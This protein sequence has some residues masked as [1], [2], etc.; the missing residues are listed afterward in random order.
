VKR[1]LDQRERREIERAR[2]LIHGVPVGGPLVDEHLATGLAGDPPDHLREV[3]GRP[4]LVAPTGAGVD[5]EE[6]PAIVPS[7]PGQGEAGLSAPGFRRR[8][9]YGRR[10]RLHSPRGERFKQVLPDCGR[11]P[12]LWHRWLDQRLG[13]DRSQAFGEVIGAGAEPGDDAIEAGE[14]RLDGWRHGVATEKRLEREAVEGQSLVRHARPPQEVGEARLGGQGE[15]SA[16]SERPERDQSRN[17]L[18]EIPQ[19]A[20]VNNQDLSGGAVSDHAGL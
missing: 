19:G 9:E 10:G 16:F 3:R 2:E 14:T 18:E 17:G 11:R 7:E 4:A 12:R 15:A 13:N 8:Q 5:E 1:R 6:R 20:W